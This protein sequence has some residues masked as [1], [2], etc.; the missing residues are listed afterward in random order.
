MSTPSR[1][2]PRQCLR[3][4]PVGLT[5]DMVV[6]GPR[7]K[8]EKRIRLRH[9][10]ACR[11]HL[12]T[13]SRS[14]KPASSPKVGKPAAS[15]I[16]S[17]GGPSEDNTLRSAAQ[18]PCGH[19]AKPHDSQQI[20]RSSPSYWYIPSQQPQGSGDEVLQEVLQTVG[21]EARCAC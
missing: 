7:S 17:C 19:Q 13:T 2:R 3:E 8:K 4:S 11:R 18:Y 21:I 6:D 12:Q 15:L 5:A 1:K 16:I 10:R 14:Q 9:R 20:P